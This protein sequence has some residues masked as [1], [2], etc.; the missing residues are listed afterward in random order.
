MRKTL[1]HNTFW[2]FVALQTNRAAEAIVYFKKAVIQLPND[3]YLH[4]NLAQAY[5][6]LGLLTEAKLAFEKAA[7]YQASFAEP[8]NQLVYY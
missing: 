8:L 6:V 5:K 1:R 7:K 4:N 3:A 2:A